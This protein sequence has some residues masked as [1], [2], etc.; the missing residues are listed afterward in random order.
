MK[1]LSLSLVIMVSL[2]GLTDLSSSA[3][4]QPGIPLVINE[5]MASN[6][7]IVKDPQGQYD[8]W[9]EIYNNDSGPIDVSGMYLTDDLDNPN[10]WRFPASTTIPAGDYILMWA[11][12][13]TADPGFHANFE[14]DADG[15]QIGLFDADGTTLIDI[16][17]FG[18][19]T[20][21]VSYGRF[22]DA[23]DNWY[24]FAAPT[25]G[26]KNTDVYLG[27]IE[28]LSFSRARGFY[29]EPFTLTIATETEGADIYY[30]LDGDEIFE[31]SSSRE[32]TISTLYT[33]PITIDRTTCLR[34]RAIKPGWK[35]SEIVTHTYIFL[36]DVIRQPVYPEGFP[37]RW[38]SNSVDY[39]M[40]PDIVYD[41]R[42]NDKIKNALTSIPTMS[43]VLKQDYMF[44]AE[45][46]YSNPNAEREKPASVELIYPDSTQEGFQVS[47][48]IKIIGGASR[49]MSKKYSFRLL[50]KG[51]YGPSKLKYPLFGPD[52]ASEFNTIVLRSSFND[53][54]GWSGARYY[55]QYTRDEFIRTLQ[56]DMGH[57]SPNSILV[58]LYINGL[59]WGLYLPCERPDASFSAGYYGGDE[60]DF[61]TFSHDGITLR[62]GNDSALN[63]MTTLCRQAS[64]SEQAYQQ[65]QGN[66]PDGSRNPDYPC[67]LDMNNYIDYLILNYAVNN[68]DWPWNNYWFARKRTDDSTG[69]KFYSWDSE[70]SL[71]LPPRAHME[72]DR[73]TDFRNVGQF[74]GCLIQNNEYRLLFADRVHHHLFNNG[75]LTP[76]YM[77]RLYL[78]IADRVEL[79]VIAES[80]RWGDMHHH[81][82]LNQDNWYQM[83]DWLLDNFFR[84][85]HDIVL[86]QLKNAGL[87]PDVEAPTFYINGAYQH[88]GHVNQPATL[89]MVSPSGTIYYTLDGSDPR[90]PQSVSQPVAVT[91]LVTRDTPEKIL[92]PAGTI[93]DEWKDHL[94][95]DDSDWISG[96]GGIGYERGSGYEA[97]IDTDVEAQMYNRNTSCYIRI[98][99]TL[100]E[101]PY[102]FDFLTL[103][104]RY[105][106]GFIA[107]IN[108][109]E[110]LRVLF[111]G[112]PA[113]NSR[114][115]SSHEAQSIE[116]FDLSDYLGELRR[117]SNV[118]AIHGLNAST[119]SSDLLI[120]AELMAGR[121]ASAGDSSFS[122]AAIEY[123]GPLTLTAGAHIKSR[124]LDNGAWSALNQATFA[125]G[126]VAQNLRITEI[127]FHPQDTGDPNEE[128]IEL[129]NI[130][131]ETLNLNLVKFT[132][133]I[134]FT[135]PDIDL[136]PGQYVVVVKDLQ[137][138][139]ARY[140][141]D[142]NI[143][144]RYSGLLANDG[145][146]I[147]LQDAVGRTI[148]DFR[149]SDKW[150]NATDGRGYSLTIIDPAGTDP[151]SYSQWH[152]WQP[153]A[154]IG[155]SPG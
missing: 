147:R 6:S 83:R 33:G 139:T 113:W 78:N 80:A 144:G 31:D 24:L 49:N 125:V 8:D 43:I 30:T 17:T 91:N 75:V 12:G 56:R 127:M 44:G 152:S 103:N 131:T 124:T 69:F 13:D 65:L 100:R 85:R 72:L 93:G 154:L 129:K 38:G 95:F 77:S 58:H 14:L 134:D 3:D 107:Y 151:N 19:Q 94:P 15:E 22:P 92:V 118:L 55:E 7:S 117:G 133:G 2:F 86:R 34:A 68:E 143:A 36:D 9:I 137:A 79:P 70:I 116:S 5:L 35:H 101:K 130:G 153:S 1:I 20:S 67:L 121:G 123:T 23:S 114:A 105:D 57:V 46:I 87:Y 99:F 89:T 62:E 104:M 45:G 41:T 119:T 97:L 40:D 122:P 60:E 25:P 37:G 53:G 64:Y 4:N 11:D 96:T 27:E 74:H 63:Q 51:I 28:N 84:Q 66:N 106:D 136:A 150:Y 26:R 120:S 146:R 109:T 82:P 18:E 148:L 88:G 98:P 126:P 115:D 32:T 135:F 50:F 111:T 108:S 138:F 145:E 47:C 29:D 54:Y 90:R 59:Y 71:Y 102:R 48:G 110:V 142:I 42:Y 140:G 73:T 52:A 61:D 149:Y 76:E 112:T 10:K 141:N 39:E 16:I 132:N 81:P 21:D 128:F 155:G